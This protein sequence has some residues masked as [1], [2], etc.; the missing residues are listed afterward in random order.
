MTLREKVWAY[1]T[2]T[3]DRVFTIFKD[4]LAMVE[5][6]TDWK[7]KCLPSDNGGEYKSDKFVQ[8]CRERAIK[9]EFTAP[10]S[11]EHNGVEEQMNQTFQEQIVSCCTIPD[12]QTVSRPRRHSRLCTLSTCRRIGPL[13][14][15]FRKSFGQEEN[16]I[17][18]SREYS[19]AKF[20]HLCQRTSIINSSYGHGN[21]FSLDMD[22]MEISAIAYGTR[23]LIKSSEVWT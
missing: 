16:R 7:L 12:L 3:T 2:W 13:D 4:W 17:M 9:R 5:N 10:Y 21:A 22:L 23:R 8:F 15:K 20:M 11:P 1:P 14:K 6:Q 18:E 19:Y